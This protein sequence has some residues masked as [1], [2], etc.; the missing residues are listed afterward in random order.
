MEIIILRRPSWRLLW[1]TVVILLSL[2]VVSAQ[3]IADPKFD[4]RV[5][6][7]AYTSSHPKVLI[8]EAH[9]NFHTREGRYK[10][11]ADLIR[12][13]GYIV[14][15]NTE[16]FSARG[17]ASSDV[18]VIANALGAERQNS[19]GAD[20]PAFTDEECASVR[21]W[22]NG[23]GALLLIADHAPFGAAA[24][25]M[26][27]RFGVEMSKGTTLDRKNHVPDGSPSTLIYTRENKLLA[28]HP[29]TRGR[30]ETERINTVFTFTG[31]SLKGPAESVALLK[32]A[33]TAL[34]RQPPDRS[35]P[36]EPLDRLPNG[37]PLPPGVQISGRRAGPETSAAGR[38][39]GIAFRLGRGRVVVLGEAAMLSAQIIQGPA[40]QLMGKESILMGMNYPGSDNRQFTLNLLHWLSGLLK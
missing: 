27:R 17:L 2:I 18:L 34:D 16:K 21:E 19:P 33:E 5:A 9:F 1:V 38:A 12:N 35:I 6:K 29:I 39:Q 36:A 32:L 22:V 14:T 3:Q 11:F 30:H 4:P 20:Q 10:P 40:A 26:A 28:D 25:I 23:G 7:P 8:D 31:Q 13:D 24:E 15:S 37:E